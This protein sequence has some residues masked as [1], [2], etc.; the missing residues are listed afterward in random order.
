MTHLRCIRCKQAGQMMSERLDD[1]LDE[2]E[3]SLLARHVSACETCR[4]EWEKLQALD[5]LFRAAP[6]VEPPVRL[7]V[8][9]MARLE[10]RHKARQTIL[11]FT[12]LSLGTVTLALL[13]IAPLLLGLLNA[14]GLA[15]AL[16]QAGPLIIRQ[17]LTF[18]SAMG[19]ACLVVLES[20]AIPLAVILSLGLV[21]AATLNGLWIGA[22]RRMQVTH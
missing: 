20:L 1:A 21:V 6:M 9:V 22:L 4:A 2:A 14:T 8:H 3:A 16:F 12:T 10:R 19:R 11:G 5:Q 17:T 18:A 7:R 13:L 15:P